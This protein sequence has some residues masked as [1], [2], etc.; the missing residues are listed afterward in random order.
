MHIIASKFIYL[1]NQ[2]NLFEILKPFKNLA[3]QLSF[4]QKQEFFKID[5]KFLKKTCD[6]FDIKILAVHAPTV[7]VFDKEF[8]SAIRL[9]KETYKVRLISIHPQRGSMSSALAKLEEYTE[10]IEDLDVI[11]AYENFPSSLV[12]KK[13]ICKPYDMYSCFNLP[14]LKLT[15]DT[16]HLDSP[17]DCIKELER[18]YD[19][20]AVIHL[21]DKNQ[22]QQHLPL[23]SGFVPYSEFLE[24]LKSRGFE[25]PL[26]LEYMPEYEARLIEDL[27]LLTSRLS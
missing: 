3:I 9:L 10:A 15:F 13:W 21:S 4:F 22:T 16:S 14:F 11:L 17:L 5:H 18:I 8:L 19:K 24:Y 23:G 2:K 20:I 25:A 27:Q 1:K 12:K 26:V 7:D 6:D